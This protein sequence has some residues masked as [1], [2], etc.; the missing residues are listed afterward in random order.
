MKLHAKD[1]PV[2]TLDGFDDAVGCEPTYSKPFTN[3]RY[4]LNVASIYDCRFRLPELTEE[5][6]TSRYHC[7]RTA[8]TLFAVRVGSL[9][10][11]FH[12]GV[13]RSSEMRV[14][15]LHPVADPKNRDAT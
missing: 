2:V 3:A 12:I 6:I 14:D 5:R 7:M 10:L 4:C 15:K 8:V 9:P 13:D 1:V 11:P